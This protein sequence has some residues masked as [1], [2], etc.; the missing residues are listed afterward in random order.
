M[1]RFLYIIII[2]SG[3]I[4]VGFGVYFL[5]KI[6][7]PAEVP[8]PSDSALPLPPTQTTAQAANV[9][10]LFD[11]PVF[12]Y[13]F[14]TQ[15][16]YLAIEPNGRLIQTDIGS[17]LKQTIAEN[18]IT[19][20]L[21][22]ERSYDGTQLLLSFGSRAA[23]LFSVYDI[24]SGSWTVLPEGIISAAWAPASSRIAYLKEDDTETVIGILSLSETP[25]DAVDGIEDEGEGGISIS[26]ER[27]TA[28]S[29]QDFI[30]N[31]VNS[32]SLF[33][34]S[35]PSARIEGEVWLFSLTQKTFQRVAAGNG[36]TIQW[37]GGGDYGIML[38]SL[39]SGRTLTLTDNFARP[40]LTLPFVTLPE[41]CAIQSKRIYCAVPT[42]IEASI[43]LPDAYYKQ[44]AYF[45]DDIYTIDLKTGESSLLVDGSQWEIDAVRLS[46]QNEFLVLK[47]RLDD[48]L[49]A[50][51]L[52][53][54]FISF[55]EPEEEAGSDEPL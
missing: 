24:P 48:K 10:L 49:Y 23:P 11:E 3:I 20:P 12:D 40:L 33:L 7:K 2:L 8:F 13:I 32:D 1:K 14:L 17:E 46:Q 27:V 41:K 26:D 34:S 18:T 39:P 31:W 25:D 22:S 6:I 21:A 53:E 35:R 15:N 9:F 4:A 51:R 45:R 52:P 16:T 30:V 54:E 47:N 38:S 36:I 44:A 29:A 37:G 43:E 28:L 5:L 42:E 55:E 50:V 19:N